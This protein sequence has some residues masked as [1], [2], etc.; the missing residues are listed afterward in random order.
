MTELVGVERVIQHNLGD[1]PKLLLAIAG[2]SGVGKYTI[3]QKILESHPGE[4]YRVRTY[5]TRKPRTGEVE[6]EQYYF[7]SREEFKQLAEEGKLLEGHGHDVYG[8]GDLYSMPADLMEG[9]PPGAHLILVEVDIHGT[10]L[11][12]RLFPGICVSIFITAP[13]DQLL[14]RI[15]S[16]DAEVDAKELAH[17]LATAR[18]QMRAAK[19]FDYLVF[20]HEDRQEHTVQVIEA[21]IATERHRVRPGVD[22]EATLPPGAFDTSHPA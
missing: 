19:D 10:A 21:I 20:N 6:G 18:E 8:H 11:L 15:R 12:K 1:V 7:V 9:T 2:P 14:E 13:P 17:R 5:T 3:T 22:L 16:R 4:M